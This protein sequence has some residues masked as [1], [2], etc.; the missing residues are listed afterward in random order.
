M[1]Y[2]LRNR[3]TGKKPRRKKAPKPKK[4]NYKGPKN[5]ASL[6]L[7][8]DRGVP[9]FD[10][11]SRHLAT[12]SAAIEYLI[13]ADTFKVPVCTVCGEKMD[14]FD[15]ARPKRFCC[16]SKD[17]TCVKSVTGET[18]FRRCQKPVNEVL[19]FLHFFTLDMNHGSI[20]R[21][22]GWTPST[23]SV[24]MQET[25]CMLASVIARSSEELRVGGPGRFVQVDE[26]KFGKAKLTRG[27]KGHPVEGSWVLGGVEL[28]TDPWG[29]NDFFA[30]CVENRTAKTLLPILR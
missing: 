3:T 12:E 23:V 17:H 30:L 28:S 8:P 13:D 4:V 14:N 11:L 20:V 2:K 15:K 9:T 18:F 5:A 29:K 19:R 6:R 26:S 25:R 7:T 1:G 24:K 27:E 22:T 10:Q 16:F 21:A